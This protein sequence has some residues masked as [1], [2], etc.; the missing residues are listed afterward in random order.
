M[1]TR[2]IFRDRRIGDGETEDT[3]ERTLLDWCPEQKRGA[4][5]KSLAQPSVATCVCFGEVRASAR[6]Y[7]REEPSKKNF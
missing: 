5:G 6:M 2:L 3:N 7:V 1:D 4:G